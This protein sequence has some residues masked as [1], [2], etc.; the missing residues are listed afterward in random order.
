M[1]WYR[2][3][4]LKMGTVHHRILPTVQELR[5]DICDNHIAFDRLLTI[6]RRPCY[7]PREHG[8]VT[9]PS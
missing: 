7:F 5:I 3:S 6:L 9:D 1:L 8:H 4:V 2:Y